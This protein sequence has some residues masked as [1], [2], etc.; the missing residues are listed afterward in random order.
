MAFRPFAP[1]LF[2][3]ELFDEFTVFNYVAFEPNAVID[4]GF[5]RQ[6]PKFLLCLVIVKV[7][8]V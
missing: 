2:I 8:A 5:I 3:V 6:N 7:R 1:R 4:S